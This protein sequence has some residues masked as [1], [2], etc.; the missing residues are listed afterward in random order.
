MPEITPEI[1]REAIENTPAHNELVETPEQ[2]E[3]DEA[4]NIH[5]SEDVVREQ[6]EMDAG[7]VNKLAEND[8]I[9]GRKEV[10]GAELAEQFFEMADQSLHDSDVMYQNYIHRLP[11]S[12]DEVLHCR[13]REEGVRALLP[14]QTQ[15]L[16]WS[17]EDLQKAYALVDELHE[18][19]VQAQE[20]KA[21]AMIERT[22]KMFQGV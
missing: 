20:A 10:S 9:L 14:S 19:T 11:D 15:A 12:E 16:L 5:E 13:M 3:M 7:L 2:R 4:T 21:D 6:R 22:N 8:E 1:A 18:K 17:G